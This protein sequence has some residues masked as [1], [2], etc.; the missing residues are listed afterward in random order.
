MGL[1][2]DRDGYTGVKPTALAA[3]I[4]YSVPAG[5]RLGIGST[6]LTGS[7]IFY[8]LQRAYGVPKWRAGLRAGVV[9]GGFVRVAAV[10]IQL[11]GLLRVWSVYGFVYGISHLNSHDFTDL[12]ETMKTPAKQQSNEKTQ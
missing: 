1:V 12:P 2:S 5:F 7:G 9:Y 3:G 11:I 6:D 10:E 8:D 4:R